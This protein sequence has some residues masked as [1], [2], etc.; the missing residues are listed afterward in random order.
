MELVRSRCA[1]SM[2]KCKQGSPY[3]VVAQ[4]E[5]GTGA[6]VRCQ[7]VHSI[8]NCK[9]GSPYSVVS[10]VELRVDQCVPSVCIADLHLALSLRKLTG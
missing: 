4:L 2:H 10:Q 3:S 5:G 8:H 6:V 7:C 1:H 9:Q